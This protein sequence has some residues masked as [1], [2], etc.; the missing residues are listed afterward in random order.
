LRAA[1]SEQHAPASAEWT[2]RIR[3]SRH[4]A[5]KSKRCDAINF[6]DHEPRSAK[7]HE[8]RNTKD[9]EPRSTEHGARSERPGRDADRR[10]RRKALVQTEHAGAWPFPKN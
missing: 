3:S 10:R 5:Q 7:D 9:H 2:L 6:K 8:P 1:D 4:W